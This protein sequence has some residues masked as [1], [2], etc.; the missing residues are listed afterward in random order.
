[1]PRIPDAADNA[2]AADGRQAAPPCRP[3]SP[4]FAVPRR[5]PLPSL[6]PA[7][8][9]LPPPIPATCRLRYPPRAVPGA[10]FPA[11]TAPGPRSLPFAVTASAR[12]RS[13]ACGGRLARRLTAQD[14]P[15]AGCARLRRRAAAGLF[16]SCGCG[17]PPRARH[18]SRKGTRQEGDPTAGRKGAG[19]G[20]D[21]EPEEWSLA[22]GRRPRH[23]VRPCDGALHLPAAGMRVSP[24]QEFLRRCGAAPGQ[25]AGSSPWRVAV[26]GARGA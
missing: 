19:T 14:A 15:P 25:P 16:A 11:V 22:R 7:L 20:P 9:S 17:G 10:R 3:R 24:L 12:L 4:P 23:G 8:R 21:S 6:M 1:M 18:G 5:G 2:Q 13:R 26:S